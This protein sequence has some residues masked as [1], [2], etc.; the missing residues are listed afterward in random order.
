MVK[1]ARQSSKLFSFMIMQGAKSLSDLRI[2]G[3]LRFSDKRSCLNM[4]SKEKVKRDFSIC[5]LPYICVEKV[6]LA[7]NRQ[8]KAQLL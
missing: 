4:V 7:R 8:K 3:L 5:G 1:T 6:I 2:F